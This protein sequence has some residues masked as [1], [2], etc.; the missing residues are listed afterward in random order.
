[1]SGYNTN[2]AAEFHVLSTSTASD[3][4]RALDSLTRVPARADRRAGADRS[5][6]P[7]A[8]IT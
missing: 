7:S 5:P 6:L 1:M 8:D 4:M 2:L 3:A